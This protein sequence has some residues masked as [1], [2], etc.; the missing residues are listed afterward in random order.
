[1]AQAGAYMYDTAQVISECLKP[2]YKDK[3]FVI[4]NTQDFAQLILEQPPLEDSKEF[5]SY[6]VE[7]L[8]TNIP[9]HDT[10]KY[11]LEEIC[12]HKELP[13]TCSKL[14]FKRLLLKFTTKITY[15]FQSQFCKQTDGCTKGGALSITFSNI[16][17]NKLE[18]LEKHN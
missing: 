5:V 10:V 3:D 7:S 14:I 11:I 17:L 16:Y 8:F 15:I 6:D 4:K 9:I 2:L 12:T 13:H 18:K 1:M